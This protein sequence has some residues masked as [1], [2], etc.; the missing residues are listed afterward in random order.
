MY[1]PWTLASPLQRAIPYQYAVAYLAFAAMLLLL[2]LSKESK[3]SP[4]DLD[5]PGMAA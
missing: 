2:S 1:L 4:A 3:E 5:P